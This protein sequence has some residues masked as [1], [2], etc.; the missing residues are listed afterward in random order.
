[1]RHNVFIA[2]LA[3]FCLLATAAF[4]QYQLDPRPY[5]PATDPDIDM[6]FNHWQNS[7]PYN[8]HG[9]ITERAIL[10][11]WDGDPLK[12]ERKGEVLVFWDSLSYGTLDAGAETTPF[13]P[14]DGQEIFYIYSGEGEI[15]SKGKTYDL[16][17]GI[18]ILVPANVEFTLKNTGDEV[19]TM[20]VIREPL[21]DG[22]KP[23]KA[24]V[25]KDETKMPYRDQGYL[26]VHWAHN[27]KNVFTN[28]DGLAELERVNLIT[29]NSMTIGQP[30]AHGPG[31]EE[32]WCVTEG[33]NAEWL[34]HHVRWMDVGTAFLVPPTGF[35]PHS[36]INCGDKPL[37]LLYVSRFR[38]YDQ[39]NLK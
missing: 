28:E 3:V 23:K 24:I 21:P 30:H 35:T 1:M 8:T 16:H 32:V 37:K 27:G 12:P 10:S 26:Q 19:M 11:H 4:A 15:T 39:R 38:D 2:S 7:T 9:A 22:F 20:Y 36:H 34:G 31:V 17:N 14:E 18:F 6:Y 33:R 25:V 5:D 13:A 29:F